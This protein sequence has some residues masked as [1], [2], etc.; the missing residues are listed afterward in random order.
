MAVR[1][2]ILHTR[3]EAYICYQHTCTST[4]YRENCGLSKS[5]KKKTKPRALDR[6]GKERGEGREYGRRGIDIAVVDLTVSL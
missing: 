4:S 1:Y 3:S 5:K 6:V 2:I